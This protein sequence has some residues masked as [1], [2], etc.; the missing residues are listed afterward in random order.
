MPQAKKIYPNISTDGRFVVFQAVSD[1]GFKAIYQRDRQL[2]STTVIA[3]DWNYAPE[4]P[5][6]SFDGRL[7]AFQTRAQLDPADT[8]DGA[9]TALTD[10]Y[11]WDR[12]TGTTSLASR[13]TGANGSD[14]EGHDP[15][16]SGDGRY[17]TFA[18]GGTDFSPDDHDSAFDIYV[19]DLQTYVTSLESRAIPG[20][21]RY[22]R[23]RGAS[24]LYLP[25]V[26][27]AERCTEPNR[28]HGAP[29]SFGSCTPVVSSSPNLTVG[30]G[31]GDPALARSIGSV[32]LTAVGDPNTFADDADIRIDFR[33]SNVMHRS[34]LS[35]YTGELLGRLAVRIT[36]KANGT[37]ERPAEGTVRDFDLTFTVPCAST[38]ATT[39][40]GLCQVA[41]SADTLMPGFAPEG[42]RTVYGLGQLRVRD[43]GPDEDADTPGDNSLLAV[44]GVFVP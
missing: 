43:G 4:Y 5:A 26:P 30:I 23:P 29:L 3:G 18:G 9:V 10:V 27:A 37:P 28:T 17:V 21:E 31:D 8:D 13:A 14:G 7:V 32:R 24:P 11:L 36:D 19:R 34:D 44:Q 12:Q 39:D 20:Y 41:T 6:M 42:G 38:A 15:A 16:I 33:L 40:G 25:L 2:N 35:D 22:V 1:S